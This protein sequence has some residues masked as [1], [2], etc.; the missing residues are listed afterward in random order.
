MGEETRAAAARRV[1]RARPRLCPRAPSEL[2]HREGRLCAS[3]STRCR[4]AGRVSTLRRVSATCCQPS[5][6]GRPTRRLALR[7]IECRRV[8]VRPSRHRLL[9][10]SVPNPLGPV[11]LRRDSWSGPCVRSV[12]RRVRIKIINQLSCNYYQLGSVTL[13]LAVCASLP[14]SACTFP[15]S[16]QREL[17]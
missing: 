8:R 13:V 10:R 16:A 5:Q 3:C 9:S 12:S 1:T 4:A 11:R 7:S 15:P 14:I 17:F 6:H 2:R